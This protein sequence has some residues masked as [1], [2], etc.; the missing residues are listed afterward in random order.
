MMLPWDYSIPL[1]VIG[2]TVAFYW[3][4]VLHMARRQ[5]KRTGKAANLVPPEPLGRLLRLLWAPVIVLWMVLPLSAAFWPNPPTAF[6]P[7]HSFH[8]IGW[9]CAAAVVGGLL[10]TR[11]CWKQM[12]RNWRMGIDPNEKTSLV[13]EGLF[14][15]V[16]HPI[17]ALSAGMMI[18]TMLALPTPAMLIAGTLHI[19]LL[20][21]ESAREERHLVATHGADYQAYQRRVGRLMPRSLRPYGRV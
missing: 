9:I 19:T 5:R 14:A 3:Q 17:Y 8:G 20:L 7:V 16:R 11:R 6:A 10:V 15:Y 21:W 4:Q 18:A 1:L 13:F 2:G 12:G